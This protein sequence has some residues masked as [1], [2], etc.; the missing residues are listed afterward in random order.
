MAKS[1]V[2]TLGGKQ[3]GNC[4]NKEDWDVIVSFTIVEE[5]F[6]LDKGEGLG[7]KKS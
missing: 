5:K 1:N 7:H 6:D 4:N 3:K 2:A